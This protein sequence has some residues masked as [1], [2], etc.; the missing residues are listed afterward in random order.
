MCACTGRN[1]VQA[2]CAPIATPS[3]TPNASHAR[4]ALRKAFTNHSI[5]GLSL[6]RLA[7]DR[8]LERREQ[9]L[10]RDA[11][12]LRGAV[13]R[14]VAIATGIDVER[15]KDGERGRISKDDLVDR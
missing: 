6:A 13:E 1:T 9:L 14:Q 5:V 15:S 7:R 11:G 10:E 2:G 12:A 8:G 4:L 3:V